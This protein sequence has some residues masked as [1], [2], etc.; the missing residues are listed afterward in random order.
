MRS[1]HGD[2]EGYAT[3]DLGVRSRFTEVEERSSRLRFHRA[4]PDDPVVHHSGGRHEYNLPRTMLGADVVIHVPKLKTH[5]KSGV[6][7]S[8][9]SA[10]GLCGRKY[11]LPHY[12]EGAAPRGD[13]FPSRPSTAQR[14]AIRLS[15]FP[16]PGGHSLIARAPRVGAVPPITEGSWEGNDTIWRT[17]LD[18]AWSLL[19][20]DASGVARSSPARRSFVLVDG[21]VAGEGEGPFGV[22]PVDLGL[23][24]AGEDCVFV[25]VVG[26]KAMGFEPE[27]IP[28]IA[29]ALSQPLLGPSL[30][31]RIDERWN[32]PPVTRPFVAPRSWPSLGP[33][34]REQ[35]GSSTAIDDWA[36]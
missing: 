32:G 18:L 8:L 31:N 26:A 14:L 16:V 21:I 24:I 9:K 33:P 22:R 30:P 11:W 2:P 5:K 6:T 17:T 7:I 36:G 34:E 27:R 23:L 35:P 12:T 29:Q 25:D 1:L 13:E 10:I 4:N 3:V 19:Y 28:T 20:V 15:R